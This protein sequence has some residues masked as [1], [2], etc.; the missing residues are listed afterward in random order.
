MEAEFGD[1]IM[2]IITALLGFAVLVAVGMLQRV[3]KKKL[4][5]DAAV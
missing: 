3:K 2:V 5:A 4:E 1:I